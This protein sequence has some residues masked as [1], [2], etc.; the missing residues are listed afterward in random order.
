MVPVPLVVVLRVGAGG[1]DLA[2][3]GI[4]QATGFGNAAQDPFAQRAFANFLNAGDN[5][6][7]AMQAGSGQMFGNTI[8]DA[9]RQFD[10]PFGQGLSQSLLGQAGNA[11]AA[12]PGTQEAAR[13]QTLD[14]LRQQ[15]QPFEERQTAGHFDRLHA[16]GQLGTTGGGIQTEAFA[17]GLGQADMQRQLA[18]GAEGRAAQGAQMQLGT[19]FL[20]GSSGLQ[21]LQNQ[22][23]SGAT[24]RFGQV[25]GIGTNLQNQG[26]NQSL[27][28]LENIFAPQMLQQQL[29]QGALGT[30]AA[31]TGLVSGLDADGRAMAELA[32]NFMVNQANTRMGQSAIPMPGAD[33][34][35]ATALAQLSGALAPEGGLQGAFGALAKGNDYGD[36]WFRRIRV[37][38]FSRTEGSGRAADSSFAPV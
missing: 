29:Q 27:G 37:R 13:Q 3:Q 36:E 28:T 12:V 30:A 35:T 19:N 2:N 16:M 20:G 5:G 9:Q 26:F 25:A 8:A 11:F 18:A 31:G 17:R 7:Q 34:S 22:L 1:V 32:G 21:E 6:L 24:S 23:L 33:T 10:N 4:T 38:R 15:A 14:L